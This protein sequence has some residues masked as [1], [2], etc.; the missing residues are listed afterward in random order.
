MRSSASPLCKVLN[1][2][3]LCLVM[4]SSNE[5]HVRSLQT[6]ETLDCSMNAQLVSDDSMC[7]STT[8]PG[9]MNRNNSGLH[10]HYFMS[11]EEALR[12]DANEHD[13]VLQLADSQIEE[14]NY[15]FFLCLLQP[16]GFLPSDGKR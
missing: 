5:E 7:A 3:I 1:F 12:V 9:S 10:V 6:G 14:G 16:V 2:I 15:L 4:K 13:D 8:L 11:E